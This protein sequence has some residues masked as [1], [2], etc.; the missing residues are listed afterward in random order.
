[1]HVKRAM[2]DAETRYGWSAIEK[3]SESGNLILLFPNKVQF[4]PVPKR[5]M[6]PA[7]A[8]ELRALIAANVQGAAAQPMAGR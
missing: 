2:R 6:T 5:A 8:G 3:S 7:Q 1:V 4:I